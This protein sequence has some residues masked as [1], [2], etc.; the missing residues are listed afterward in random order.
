MVHLFQSFA[1]IL[2][3]PPR[4]AFTVPLI[5]RDVAWYGIFFAS[6]FIFGFFI[7]IYLFESALSHL[8]DPKSLRQQAIA[9][10]DRVTWLVVL[11][12]LV[13]ARLGHVFLYD[14][15][16]YQNDWLAI[17][18][19]WEGG[20]ASHGGTV[21]IIAALWFF[22]RS[23]RKQYPELTFVRL[24]DLLAIPAALAGTLIRVGNF[25]NQEILGSETTVPWA[26]VFG[27]PYDGGPVSPRHPVQLYEAACYFGIFIL[28][29]SLWR[30]TRGRLK[31]GL[32][33]GLFMI[34]VFGAR[35]LME[36]F[37]NPQSRVLDETF[38]S[39][40]QLLSLPFILFG[41][42]LLLRALRSKDLKGLVK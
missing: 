2:W 21:G 36:F 39:A 1:W 25:F 34:S 7:L 20:L 6:G 26:V 24:L 30:S 32:L 11:G 35:F 29:F 8:K 16:L 10:T 28:L 27:H 12:T 9:L 5:Q 3:D 4:Y 38:L 33:I 18:K 40:G 37:K 15:P 41:G 31:E 17:L 23:I 14:W 42:L 22:A 19:V 13:G